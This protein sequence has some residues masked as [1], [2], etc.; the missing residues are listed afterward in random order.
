[1]RIFF[2]FICLCCSI[3]LFGQMEREKWWWNGGI[4][5]Q[6]ETDSQER[7]LQVG[8][9]LTLSGFKDTIIH[10]PSHRT[11]HRANLGVLKPLNEAWQWGLYV[12]YSYLKSYNESTSFITILDNT[13][14][15]FYTQTLN[16]T[17]GWRIEM[18]RTFKLHPK[19]YFAS[20][21]GV[22][23]SYSNGKRITETGRILQPDRPLRTSSDKFYTTSWGLGLYPRFIW[24][25]RERFGIQ[26]Q[27]GRITW[28]QA[29]VTSSPN[30]QPFT[31]FYASINPSYWT[32][33]V[34]FSFNKIQK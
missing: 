23:N 12:N 31:S 17:F 8:S 21:L 10:F 6:K 3:A 33:S 24:F 2:L 27:V 20:A 26:A 19:L 5:Y 11:F 15:Y 29:E 9:T 22:Y 18:Q 7:R 28:G 30:S 25:P 4:S 14:P 34:F 1:M 13:S 32:F 16:H